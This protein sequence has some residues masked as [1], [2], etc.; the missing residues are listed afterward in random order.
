[1][2][3]A[4]KFR[5]SVGVRRLFD[6]ILAEDEASA[7]DT[8]WVGLNLARDENGLPVMQERRTPVLGQRISSGKISV[9]DGDPIADL[10]WR[11]DD[12]SGGALVHNADKQ[13]N[14]Y[15][16]GTFDAAWGPLAPGIAKN[17]GSDRGNTRQPIGWLIRNPH[18]ESDAN[19]GWTDSSGASGTVDMQST[20]DFRSAIL[21]SQSCEIVW[22]GTTADV[23]IITQSLTNPTVYQSKEITVSCYFKK[24]VGSGGVQI[25]IDDGVGTTRGTGITTA[26]DY[27]LVTCTRTIDASA[28]E[29]TITLETENTSTFTGY[30]DDFTVYSGASTLDPVGP[31]A[32]DNGGIYMASGRIVAKLNVGTTDEFRWDAVYIHGSAVATD[33]VTYYDTGTPSTKV[34]VAFGAAA[35]YI[36]GSDTTWT[37]STITGTGKNAVYWTVSRGTL[38]KSESASTVRSST[39]PL[40]GGSWS[41][42]T[43]NIGDANR[44]ITELYSHDDTVVVGKEDGYWKYH[45]VYNDGGSADLFKNITNEFVTQ[46]NDRHFKGGA[47]FIDGMLYM[48]LGRGGMMRDGRGILEDVSDIFTKPDAGIN[49]VVYAMAPDT[50]NLWTFVDDRLVSLMYSDGQLVPHTRGDQ[51]SVSPQALAGESVTSKSSAKSAGTGAN[52]TDNGSDAWSSPGNVTASDDSRAT[53][54]KLAIYQDSN[55]LDSDNFAFSI[56]GDAEILGIQVDIE[57]VSST[58]NAYWD[59]AVRLLKAGAVTGNNKASGYGTFWPTVEA[60]ATYG[61]AADLWG[62]TWTPADINHADFGVRLRV[63]DQSGGSTETASVDHVQITVTYQETASS[64]RVL[65]PKAAG[66]VTWNV[67]SVETPHLLGIYGGQDATDS[68]PYLV[69][70]CWALPDEG[71]AP[72]LDSSDTPA[73]PTTH[74]WYSSRWSA[75]SPTELKV[76]SHLDVKFKNMDATQAVTWK[77][78]TDGAAH[79]TVSLG[80]MNGSDAVQTLYFGSVTSPQENT[81]FNDIALYAE[82]TFTGSINKRQIEA[83]ELHAWLASESIKTW[84]LTVQ[85]SGS[86]MG[87]GQDSIFGTTE[88]VDKLAQYEDPEQS[89]RW[90]YLIEDFDG[91]GEPTST[92]V[93]FRPGEITKTVTTIEGEGGGIRQVWNIVLQESR[94][95]S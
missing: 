6:F 17:Y 18:F 5:D 91:D 9:E 39:A 23:D 33:I 34:Y 84:L 81:V 46:P 37:V 47:E 36:Y 80:T 52:N 29:V 82:G 78:G 93:S 66:V 32:L 59:S 54:T 13:N 69:T 94:N 95:I 12:W 57:R 88:I 10:V 3:L 42:T 31:V 86:V 65:L 28:T 68:E 62:T 21:G 35:A 92:P 73:S 89:P 77:F 1:M 49:G 56:P 71:V 45:R 75:E 24:T 44:P 67:S 83:F 76:A 60:T 90:L 85:V 72:V 63:Q 53:V 7:A 74:T 40:N 26:T 20:T 15:N 2:A 79:D 51:P 61:G 70:D 38:W 22:T 16:R 50:K 4:G 19:D 64:S 87:N 25:E 30:I 58:A 14:G 11:Q 41:G 43:Y 27:T 8:T 55:N 48:P